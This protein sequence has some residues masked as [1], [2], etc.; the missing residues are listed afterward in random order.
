MYCMYVCMYVCIFE[1]ILFGS[2]L[3]CL[4]KNCMYVF[5]NSI[6]LFK[7][8]SVDKILCC[9]GFGLSESHLQGDG[10][11]GQFLLGHRNEDA[12]G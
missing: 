7:W 8:N 9:A 2:K 1:N 11:C 5:M 12:R 4:N 6:L 3:V 10:G